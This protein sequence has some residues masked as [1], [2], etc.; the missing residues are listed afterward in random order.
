[1]EVMPL[2]NA[3]DEILARAKRYFEHYYVDRGMVKWNGY[4]LSDHTE[5][6]GKYTQERANERNQVVMPEMSLEN[7]TAILFHAYSNHL[8]VSVQERT[9]SSGGFAPPLITGLVV[10]FI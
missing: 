4:Y 2:D 3:R 10:G 9:L 8:Q 5:S 6:V 7:I 1:M